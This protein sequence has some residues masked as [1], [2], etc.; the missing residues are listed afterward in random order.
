MGEGRQHSSVG[1]GIVGLG[2]PESRHGQGCCLRKLPHFALLSSNPPHFVAIEFFVGLCLCLCLCSV[3]LFVCVCVCSPKPESFSLRCFVVIQFSVSLCLFL[4]L[5]SISVRLRLGVCVFARARV[6]VWLLLR[7]CS[8]ACV[9][10]DVFFS[11][12]RLSVASVSNP[13]TVCFSYRCSG[14]TC[15]CITEVYLDYV[16]DNTIY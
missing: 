11:K 13:N 4:C 12:N 9:R 7:L 15:T 6:C 16:Y 5:F 14:C 2:A 10:V 3:S 1:E 8:R